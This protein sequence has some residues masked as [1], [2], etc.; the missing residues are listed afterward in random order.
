[1]G[2]LFQRC[3]VY[4]REV[5]DFGLLGSLPIAIL[6]LASLEET[7]SPKMSLYSNGS[8]ARQGL[9]LVT[10]THGGWAVAQSPMM[11]TTVAIDRLRRIGYRS[12]SDYYR[13]V[14]PVLVNRLIPDGILL[15]EPY[16][17]ERCTGYRLVVSHLL[18]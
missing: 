12:F 11:R 14:S 8:G 3:L 4:A 10:F 7:K 6:Y 16:R 15:R 18:D 13:L 1:M 9:F 5:E 2:K 17:C